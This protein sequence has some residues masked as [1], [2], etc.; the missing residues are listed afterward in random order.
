MPI[1]RNA[2]VC[3]LSVGVMTSLFE[4]ADRISKFID[5]ISSGL[6]GDL[7]RNKLSDHHPLRE[8]SG[9]STYGGLNRT[10]I[11]S[12][13]N[14]SEFCLRFLPFIS[15]AD[16]SMTMYRCVRESARLIYRQPELREIT[17]ESRAAPSYL[18]RLMTVIAETGARF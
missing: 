16:D 6:S 1:H 4:G 12:H 11:S 5:G 3:P 2:A 14:I 10:L 8:L 15:T 9:R 13:F 17:S 7:F 18:S